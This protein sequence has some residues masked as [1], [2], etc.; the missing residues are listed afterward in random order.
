MLLTTCEHKTLKV[1]R[2]IGNLLKNNRKLGH[3]S[4][5][6]K[7]QILTVL[8][9]FVVN[10]IHKQ[11]PQSSAIAQFHSYS[12][13]H[14]Y[15]YAYSCLH[16]QSTECLHIYK[17]HKIHDIVWHT[18]ALYCHCLVLCIL[19]SHTTI[20]CVWLC[21]NAVSGLTHIIKPI[22]DEIIVEQMNVSAR[23]CYSKLMLLA[24]FPSSAVYSSR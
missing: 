15:S 12:H 8:F 9:A 24:P 13:S 3:F 7:V 14:S 21:V 18:V 1:I 22:H 17:A 4:T 16:V 6:V 23:T 11:N 19:S 10:N 20:Y 2:S 5:C